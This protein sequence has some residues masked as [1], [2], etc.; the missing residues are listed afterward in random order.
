MTLY[1]SYGFEQIVTLILLL[2]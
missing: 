1:I 2:L